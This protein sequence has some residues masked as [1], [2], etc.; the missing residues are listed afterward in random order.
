MM[1]DDRVPNDALRPYYVATIAAA[2]IGLLNHIALVGDEALLPVSAI[3][4][5]ANSMHV[6]RAS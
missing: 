5:I 2:Y 3:A 4:E 6:V 1:G